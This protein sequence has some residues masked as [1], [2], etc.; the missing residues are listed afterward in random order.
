[1]LVGNGAPEM[2]HSRQL[3]NST[4]DLSQ[5]NKILYTEKAHLTNSLEL[6]PLLSFVIVV[7][8]NVSRPSIKNIQFNSSVQFLPSGVFTGFTL[9]FTYLYQSTI[10]KI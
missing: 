8:M 3:F 2:E 10:F 4:L 7:F 1:V 6:E 5:E 9:F